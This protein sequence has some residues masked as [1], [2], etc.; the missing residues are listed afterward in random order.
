MH[1]QA[2]FCGAVNGSHCLPVEMNRCWWRRTSAFCPTPELKRKLWQIIHGNCWNCW[3]LATWPHT[4]FLNDLWWYHPAGY[5]HL[6]FLRH[7]HLW[8]QGLMITKAQAWFIENHHC[9]IL[10]SRI[11]LS[12]G[13]NNQKPW[14]STFNGCMW[15]GLDVHQHQPEHPAA[16][17]AKWGRNWRHIVA[18]NFCGWIRDVYKSG[19]A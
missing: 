3:K 19:Y 2:Y 4:H 18:Y 12:T 10:G 5:F 1:V 11:T 17:L 8:M 14:C 13:G 15:M 9:C 7:L 6:D 16:N